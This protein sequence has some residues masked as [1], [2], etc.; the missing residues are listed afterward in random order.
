MAANEPLSPFSQRLMHHPYIAS[1]PQANQ[2]LVLARNNQLLVG[3]QAWESNEVQTWLKNNKWAPLTDDGDRPATLLTGIPNPK[4]IRDVHIYEHELF[5]PANPP[6]VVTQTKALRQLLEHLGLPGNLASP[7]HVLVSAPYESSCPDGAPSPIPPI[8]PG[9][10]DALPA[11]S[12]PSQ[13]ITV[14]D[15]GWQWSTEWGE[16]PLGPIGPNSWVVAESEAEW[17]SGSWGWAAPGPPPYVAQLLNGPTGWQPGTPDTPGEY[18]QDANGGPLC[19]DEATQ[20]LAPSTREPQLVAL[21]GHANFIAGMIAQKTTS[22]AIT[23]HNFNGAFQPWAQNFPDEIAV[24]R[25]LVKSVIDGSQLIAV[26]FAF[27]PL[28]GV[29]SCVWEAAFQ[30]IG[31]DPAVVAPAGN[32]GVQVPRYPAA[33]N[34]P[35]PTAS[36][37][38]NPPEGLFE[39]IIGVASI[40]P[41]VD[42]TAVPARSQFSNYGPW[43]TCATMGSTVTS[44]FLHV[45]MALEDG[46][47]TEVG[48]RNFEANSWAS[49][50]GTSFAAPSFAAVV[51]AEMARQSSKGTPMTAAAAAKYVVAQANAGFAELGVGPLWL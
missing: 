6:A 44:T 47:P 33:L 41:F 20:R 28:D 29:P 1:Y 13:P 12:T 21:A 5:H 50:N 27:W 51:L 37:P 42:A 49:W 15:S 8:P 43:V 2:G 48:P 7:N 24:A 38:W 40:E 34:T 32:Q 10:E 25:A 4:G 17:P 16:N 39:S 11:Q 36:P 31:P 3:E 9:G 45:N 14:I 19:W 23:I 26:G 35:D 18:V 46:P 22:A 30:L